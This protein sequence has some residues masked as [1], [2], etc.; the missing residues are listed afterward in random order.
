MD[1]LQEILSPHFLLR[2]SL[3]ASL[4]VGLVCPVVGVFLVL[5]RLVF[6][7]VALP[8]IS[9]T[10]VALVLLLPFWLGAGAGGGHTEHSEHLLAL[11]G[12]VSFTLAAVLIL[13]WLERR[14][15]GVPEGR[16]GAV[17]VVASALSIL[18]LSRNRYAEVGWLDLLKG[19]IITV[20]TADLLI[21]AI[22]LA[23]VLV[24]M[25][26]FYKELLMVSFDRVL[27]ATLGRSVVAWDLLLY[28]LVG[29]TVSV[30][31]LSVGPL[32]AFGFLLVPALIAH[33]FARSMRQF[34]VAS[35]AIG[36]VLAFAGF[37]L[38]YHWDWP[39]GP[40][41]VALLGAVYAG[42]WLVRRIKG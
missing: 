2:N 6:V 17:Y 15:Q 27:A 10:G 33:L 38:A 40:T 25:A 9:S 39:V 5:R 8:Q 34:M 14:A 36:G 7:G 1:T 31:V 20:D 13:A 19:E 4:L 30:C 35:A 22:T 23:L 42:A 16:L 21:T 32:V 3:Y 37:A 12:S 26:V 29:L 11:M 41:E 24:L 18:L 28:G